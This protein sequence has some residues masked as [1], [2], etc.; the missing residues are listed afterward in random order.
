MKNIF[1]GPFQNDLEKY[2]NYYI[3]G[4]PTMTRIYN[5]ILYIF[6]NSTNTDNIIIGKDNYL[7]QNQYTNAYFNEP[8]NDN[9]NE[10]FDKLTLLVLLQQKIAKM[11]KRL[12]VI[13]TPSKASVYPEYLPRAFD[14]YLSMKNRGEYAQ[15]YYDYFVSRV[16]ET[17]LEYFNFHD[18][19]IKM[20]DNGTDI[21]AKSGIHWNAPAVAAYFSE[22]INELNK[23]TDKKIGTT[24]TIKTEPVWGNAFT[25]DNDLEV[26]LNIF[27]AYK[28]FQPRVRIILP[29]YQ[30]L[31]PRDKFYSY[32]MEL[33]SVPTDYHPSVF[34]CGGSFN[35]G[36]IFMVYGLSGWVNQTDNYIFSSTEL[37]FYN[38]SVTKYPEN[39][40]I[41]DATDDFYSI[42]DKDIIIIE[43]NEPHINPDSSQFVFAEN[44]LGFI[45]KM[46]N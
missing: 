15:N 41:A 28:D 9:K 3:V 33:L 36:W 46:G 45:E 1:T 11:D 29:F 22:L 21:F 31:F 34:V 14:R 7:F 23:D 8:T 25:T 38:S 13:I 2:F 44:L 43:F 17:G 40:T 27:L 20:K 12:F 5:Q 30:Y 16:G 35:A 10:L 37:S 26:L 6:F 18:E 42:L 39:I 32:H 24:Q 4:R 19:F